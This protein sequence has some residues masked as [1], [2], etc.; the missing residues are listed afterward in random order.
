MAFRRLEE[1]GMESLGNREKSKYWPLP[2]LISSLQLG[3]QKLRSQRPLFQ[4]EHHR[5]VSAESAIAKSRPTPTCFVETRWEIQVSDIVRERPF[6]KTINTTFVCGF[7]IMKVWK[8]ISSFKSIVE[9]VL[10]LSIRFIWHRKHK[11]SC[12]YSNRK[13]NKHN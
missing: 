13:R 4:V 6:L 3:I 7:A 5:L 12:S 10:S 8:Q 2:C 11:G 9:V 1:E